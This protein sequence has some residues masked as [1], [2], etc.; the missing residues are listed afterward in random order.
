MAKSENSTGTVIQSWVSPKFAREIRELAVQDGRSVSNLIKVALRDRL[1]ET[2]SR[3]GEGRPPRGIGG[4]HG[5][6]ERGSDKRNQ[7]GRSDG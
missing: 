1:S 5:P 6:A 3:G 4:L 2:S 7:E